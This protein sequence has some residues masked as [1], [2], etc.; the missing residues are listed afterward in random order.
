MGKWVIL[1][2][3]MMVSVCMI[4]PDRAMAQGGQNAGMSSEALMQ[5]F[6]G[7]DEESPQRRIETQRKHE[8]LFMMGVALL[9]LL[10][11]TGGMGIAMAAF[12]KDVFIA[13]TILA[14]L[15]LTLA[16]VHAAT[17]IAWFWPY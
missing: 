8:I 2:F 5:Q 3:L 4:A 7:D 15:T 9:V 13:H 12:D 10:F 6:A 17:S 11:L 16:A 1:G 14:G